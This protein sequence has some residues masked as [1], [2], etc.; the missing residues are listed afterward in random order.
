MIA[1]FERWSSSI[2]TPREVSTLN[3]IYEVMPN[4]NFSSSL[5]ERAPA[6]IAVLELQNVLWSDWGKPE[7]I[8][9]TLRR[10]DKTPAF[11]LECLDSPFA[12]I[13]L[14]N[15]TMQSA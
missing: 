9:E 8:A 2:G 4:N 11:P 10:I 15:Q 6:H 14:K 12:P 7:R 1:L 5:L 3:E 13:P